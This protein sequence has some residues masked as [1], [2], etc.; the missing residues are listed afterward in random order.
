MDENTFVEVDIPEIGRQIKRWRS[1]EYN[2]DFLTPTDGWSF[3]L[4]DDET[5]DK[6]LTEELQVGLRVT[7]KVNGVVQGDGYIDEIDIGSNRTGGTEIT[8]SG[9]DL[10]GI[11][12]DAN[13]PAGTTIVEKQTLEDVMR[14]VFGPFGFSEFRTDNAENRAVIA[15][16]TNQKARSSRK[17]V[18]AP[19]PSTG[20][21]RSKKGSLRDYPL[22]Q[23]K[24]FPGEGAFAFAARIAQLQGLWIWLSH[25]G[26]LIVSE[27][28]YDQSPSASI[29]R[30]RSP[31]SDANNVITGGVR[32]S[33]AEQ[34]SALICTGRGGGGEHA[35]AGMTVLAL[36]NAVGPTD[37]AV[38][39]I[40]KYKK[41]RATIVGFNDGTYP[42]PRYLG[43]GRAIYLHDDS[44]TTP[45]ELERF[46]RRELALRQRKAFEAHY[47]VEGHVSGEGTIWSVDTMVQVEDDIANIHE[48]LYVLSRTF[49]KSRTGGT[50]TDLHLIRPHTMVF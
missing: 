1:Y 16:L 28:D 19:K 30:K 38:A 47:T 9:R 43:K 6:F 35:R 17:G 31:A 7:T 29:T 13:V 8:V 15:G 44:A 48:P 33:V 42:F 45:E 4:A 2:S 37:E 21:R 32:R 49:R 46:A 26:A 25:D 20:K 12:I 34:P 23:I 18:P 27:P 11:T 40:E 10:L 14:T 5:G 22:K 41:Q 50:T 39:L 36:N 3:Q 24:A